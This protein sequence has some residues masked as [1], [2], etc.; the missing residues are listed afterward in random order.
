[1]RTPPDVAL[2]VPE[3]TL[4]GYP[5]MVIR[6]ADGER[7]LESM[8]WGFPLRLKGMKPDSKPKPVNNIADLSKPMWIGLGAKPQGRCLIPLTGFAEPAGPKGVKARTWVT[9]K[10]QPIFA[11]GGLWRE[12]A[13][14]GLPIRRRWLTATKRYGRSKIECR[15]CCTPTNISNGCGDRL[16]ISSRSR[17]AAFPVTSSRYSPR[18]TFG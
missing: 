2:N 5:G 18:V 3:E 13:E 14:W 6:E 10:G 11:W 16:K 15:S 8:V 4:P 12:S 1:V 9:V 7:A 17:S